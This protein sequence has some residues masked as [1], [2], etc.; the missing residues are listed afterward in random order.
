MRTFCGSKDLFHR[1]LESPVEA[2]RLQIGLKTTISTSRMNQQSPHTTPEMADTPQPSTCVFLEDPPCNPS[3]PWLLTTI[4]PQITALL[5]SSCHSQCLLHQQFPAG[6][7]V[8]LTGEN[9]T[10]LSN[11]PIWISRNSKERMILSE[12]L[13][14]SDNSSTKQSTRPSH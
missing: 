8:E 9:L 14:T 1:L 7:G 5:P 12:Q 6:V 3:C 4:L 11:L 2:K 13:P 10:R